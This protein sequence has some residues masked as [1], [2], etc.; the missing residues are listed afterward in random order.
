[1]TMTASE[2]CR[3]GG[4]DFAIGS[5]PLGSMAAIAAIAAIAIDV[6]G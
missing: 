1:M 6:A 5:A 4:F 2:G 3:A